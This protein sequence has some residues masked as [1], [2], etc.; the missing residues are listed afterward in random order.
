MQ[1][2]YDEPVLHNLLF[3]KKGEKLMKL[4]LTGNIEEIIDGL[5]IISKDLNI[6]RSEDG[7]PLHIEKR[8]GPIEVQNNK[9][10]GM[11]RYEEKIHFFRAI[12]LWVENYMKKGEFSISET[13]QFNVNGAMIDCSRNAVMTVEGIQLLLRKM[14]LM[15]LNTVMLYTEDTFT[16]DAY[17]YFGYMRGRYTKEEIKECDEYA[18]TLGIELVPCIQTLAHLTE[19][20]KWQYA[21]E[22]KDT[23]D[24]LLVGSEKTYVFIEHLIDSVSQMFSTDRIHIGM[25]EAHMLGLGKYLELNGYKKR[26]DIMNEHLQQ[27]SKITNKYN[28]RPMIWSD[29]YF[30]LG[31]KNGDYY[32]LDADIPKDAIASIPENVE[33][34]YWDYYH[35]DK[36][37]YNDFIDKHMSFDRHLLFAGG[38]WTW[39]GIAP[40]YGKTISTTNAALAACK[41]KGVKEVFAT[42]WGDNGAETNIFTGLA[43]LQ[44][45]AEHGYAKEVDQQ[46]LVD[47]FSSCVGG[48]YQDFLELNR[49]DEVPG[50][51]K[52]NLRESNPSKFLLWEDILIGLY[53]ENIKGLPLNEHY[54]DLE[55][56]LNDAK[57]RNKEWEVIFDFYIQLAKTLSIKAEFG[58]KL[59]SAFDAKDREAMKRLRDQIMPLREMTDQLRKKHRTLWHWSNKSFGWEILDIRYGGV[60]SRL[61]TAEFKLS[62]WIDGR[63]KTIEELEIERLYNNDPWAN[64][65]GIGRGMYHRI[66]TAGS[67]SQ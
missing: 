61:E 38:V 49:F 30:R 66:V 11:I 50:V 63:I 12:S 6:E 53:D 59:K 32:D 3:N 44:L 56:K 48:S 67:F 14:S 46:R 42:M 28:M 34:V 26:F 9:Q 27:V 35:A 40:N 18:N 24:I 1:E 36:E 22:I 19:A 51:A 31:S 37:F 41:E 43:G 15:G 54:K 4:H 33:L 29:M 7:W 58:K 45:F 55:V 47:R 57:N 2:L 25:D 21:S 23:E 65:G 20:L 5:E 13:P 64:D 52:D 39:N 8:K 17:P 60:L 62:E 10:N 16:V